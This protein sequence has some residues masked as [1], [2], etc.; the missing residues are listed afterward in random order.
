MNKNSFCWIL[1]SAL[2]SFDGVSFE[3]MV[4]TYGIKEKFASSGIKLCS[5][6]KNIDISEDDEKIPYENI[7]VKNTLDEVREENKKL[8]EDIDSNGRTKD[9]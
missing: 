7:R 2:L 6:L 9:N 1:E 4:N 5:Y 8:K 3:D